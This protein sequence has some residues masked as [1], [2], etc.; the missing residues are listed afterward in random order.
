MSN[1]AFHIGIVAHHAR[2][3]QAHALQEQVRATY[4]HMDNGTV[5]CNAAHRKAWT[6]LAGTESDWAV[7]LED[8]AVPVDGFT[9]QLGQALAVAPSPIVSLYLGRVRPPHFQPFVE[10]ALTQARQ[11]NSCWLTGKLLHAV[12]VAI[13]TDHIRSMLDES[14]PNLPIDQ[15]IGVW[16]RNQGIDTAYTL[17]SLVDHD[18][19]PTLIEHHDKTPRLPGRVAWWTGTRDVWTDK[20]TAMMGPKVHD[21]DVPG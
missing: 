20:A 14:D 4:V 21:Y 6:Y 17:P 2:A 5:G 12:G 16:A 11:A 13:R 18:D 9:Q 3:D 7:T 1:T 8:D 19:G 10:Q 15:S